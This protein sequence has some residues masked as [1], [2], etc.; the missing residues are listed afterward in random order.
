[1]KGK[2]KA[3]SN[4][5]TIG[6]NIIDIIAVKRIVDVTALSG[7]SVTVKNRCRVQ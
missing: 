5:Q 4:E 3:Q 7:G 6:I 2:R 1:M